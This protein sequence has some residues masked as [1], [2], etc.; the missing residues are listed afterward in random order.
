MK[1]L[2]T[3]DDLQV[4]VDDI[5]VVNSKLVAAH[6]MQRVK[7]DVRGKVF[8]S[9]LCMEESKKYDEWL[10][11]HKDAATILKRLDSKML[12]AF[13]CAAYVYGLVKQ[14]VDVK[15]AG[16]P[17]VRFSSYP[18]NLLSED[19]VEVSDYDDL[20]VLI[21]DIETVLDKYSFSLLY[22]RLNKNLLN[23]VVCFLAYCSMC[24]SSV[25]VYDGGVN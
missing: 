10:Y 17:F 20:K 1:P 9:D 2:T 6:G 21:P 18:Y 12:I 3:L 11:V 23:G 22:H 13:R 19:E 14:G 7:D 4:Y 15:R 16:E 24:D 5:D 25:F 8:C